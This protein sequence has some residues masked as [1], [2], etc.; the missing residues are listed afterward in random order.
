MTQLGRATFTRRTAGILAALLG[1]RTL[2]PHGDAARGRQRRKRRRKR[3][4]PSACARACGA[5]CSFCFHRA[6]GSLLCG[7]GAGGSCDASA[8]C[9]S[10]D[11]CSPGPPT[12]FCLVSSEE[13]AT[14]RITPTCEPPGGHC[15]Q[16]NVCEA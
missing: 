11:D 8:S 9:A 16:V 12:H 6:A 13:P 3:P 14:G 2:L 4:A 7:D 1:A 5:A 10:D 15:A